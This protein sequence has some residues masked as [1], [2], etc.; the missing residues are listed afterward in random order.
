MNQEQITQAV[1]DKNYDTYLNQAGWLAKDPSPEVLKLT[2]GVTNDMLLSMWTEYLAFTEGIASEVY[3]IPVTDMLEE[4]GSIA[5]IEGFMSYLQGALD[6]SFHSVNGNTYIVYVCI[7]YIL[8]LVES[9]I[10]ICQ[11]TKNALDI[12]P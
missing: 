11:I 10:R 4:M 5:L 3:G 12:S 1:I 9:E 2:H 8:H 7:L 6:V